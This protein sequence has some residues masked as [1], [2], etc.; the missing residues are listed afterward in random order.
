MHVNTYGRMR[1]HMC[2]TYIYIFKFTALVSKRVP[3]PSCEYAVAP[4]RGRLL[5]YRSSPGQLKRGKA[6][7]ADTDSKQARR[8]QG[9]G[10]VSN[11]PHYYLIFSA[12]CRA[13]SA[14]MNDV[15][16][17]VR[18]PAKRNKYTKIRKST[19]SVLFAKGVSSVGD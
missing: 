2:T 16:M 13:A 19:I 6:V 8:T 9:G 11:Q 14:L 18:S 3:S 12:G 7:A 4:L 1:M 10:S 17:T 5:A 15:P